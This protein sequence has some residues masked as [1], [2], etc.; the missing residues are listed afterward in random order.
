MSISALI[1]TASMVQESVLIWFYQLMKD[2]RRCDPVVSDDFR[3][4]GKQ[5]FDSSHVI[6]D[7]YILL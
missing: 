4:I 7:M 1:T 6:L 5:I 2:C 3:I